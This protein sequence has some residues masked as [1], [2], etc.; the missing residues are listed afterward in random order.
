[1]R[2]GQ[3]KPL[4]FASVVGKRLDEL[5][6]QVAALTALVATIPNLSD[7]QIDQAKKL[8]EQN[9]ALSADPLADTGTD[10]PQ[11]FALNTLEQIRKLRTPKMGG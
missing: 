9:D 6:G 8:I 4:E 3:R 2:L 7:H 10:L 1:M 5:A 11:Q